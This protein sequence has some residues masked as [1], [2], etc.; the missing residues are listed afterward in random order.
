LLNCFRTENGLYLKLGNNDPIHR[1]ADYQKKEGDMKR[2]LCVAVLLAVTSLAAGHALGQAIIVDHTCTDITKI[3]DYWI[4]KAK[5]K[6]F[7][8]AHTSHGSQITSGL[9]WLA[10]Q[11]GKYK[12]DIEVSGTV[13]QPT[14]LTA[15]RMYDGN[16]KSGDTYI[17]PELYWATADGLQYTRSVANTGWFSYSMWS[18]CGQQSSNSV[19]TVD[20]Y[21]G[22][23][24][25]LE[26]SYPA[27]TFIYMT[28]HTDGTSGGT[29]ARNNDRVRDYV[30]AHDKVLFDFADIETYDP[31]GGGPYANDGNGTCRWCKTWCNS[32]AGYCDDL[33]A[34]CAHTDSEPEQKLFCKLKAQAFWWLMAR[35]AGWEGVSNVHHNLRVEKSGDGKGNITAQGLTCKGKTCTGTFDEN[36]LITVTAQ[37]LP[38]SVFYGWS[39]CGSPSGNSCMVTMTA[40]VTLTA[41]FFLPQKIAVS[42]ASLAFGNLKKGVRSETRRIT[43]ANKGSN[44]LTISTVEITGTSSAA[45]E[46]VADTCTSEPVEKKG[47]CSI[48]VALNPTTYGNLS[49]LILIY[50]DDSKKS[51]SQVKVAGRSVPPKIVTAPGALDFGSRGIGVPTAKP[52]RVT[53]RGL[54][55]FSISGVAVTGA[56]S[57]FSITGND[58]GGLLQAGHTCTITITFTPDSKDKEKDTLEIRTDDTALQT[59][60]VKLS[61]K[62]K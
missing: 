2:L 42:P 53:N 46:I 60:I 5:E 22:A 12:V 61:G 55:D 7:H 30:Q 18:W 56:A 14:D 29:L 1:K 24:N 47:T 28:G 17:T 9:E 51:L 35:L 20:E 3:P 11:D 6:A 43:V 59:V 38:G 58:C 25:Q 27:M 57:P 62:G 33:P 21:L 26:V 45:T 32:H 10:G 13:V 54:S 16:N 31:D 49:S 36:A 44:P 4:E 37:A 15:L 41:T 48:D 40:D 39:G 34:S 52:V 23:L 8:F 50:S 19:A